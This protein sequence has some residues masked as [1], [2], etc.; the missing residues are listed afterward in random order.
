MRASVQNG[1]LFLSNPRT[2]SK[3]LRALLTPHADFKVNQPIEGLHPHATARQARAMVEADWGRAWSDFHVF[4]TIRNPWARMASFWAF[5][6]V[7]PASRW[8]RLR[9]ETSHDFEA[10]CLAFPGRTDLARFTEASD[11]TRLVQTIVPIE[12]ASQRLPALWRELG[13]D[14]GPAPHLNR[15]GL[16][17]YRPLYTEAAHDQV[18]RLFASDIAFAGYTFDQLAA[19]A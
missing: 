4:T 19:A 5:G 8:A 18:A 3:S 15:S 14:V 11:G 9:A 13:L 12:Q 7:N 17:D 10:F 16:R 6:A 2:G 1:W